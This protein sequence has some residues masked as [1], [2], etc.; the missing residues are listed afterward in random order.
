M[1]GFLLLLASKVR[2]PCGARRVA[3]LQQE[4]ATPRSAYFCGFSPQGPALPAS[5][6]RLAAP[7]AS[8]RQCRGAPG[9]AARR[10]NTACADRNPAA[11]RR[12]CAR[13]QR[14]RCDSAPA[15]QALRGWNSRKGSVLFPANFM[16][17]EPG[18][19]SFLPTKFIRRL[20]YA[21]FA[22]GKIVLTVSAIVENL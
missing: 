18:R 7:P 15:G 5:Q 22:C 13:A 10:V 20:K 3:L 4:I 16:R 11:P 6:P 17:L 14:A 21:L 1:Q 12:V 19:S 9:I 8:H 2:V